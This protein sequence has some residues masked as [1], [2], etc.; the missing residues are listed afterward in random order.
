MAPEAQ[1]KIAHLSLFLG[2]ILQLIYVTTFITRIDEKTQNNKE[3]I[4]HLRNRLADDERLIW[5]NGK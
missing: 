5:G 3:D 1:F 2:F 4:Q